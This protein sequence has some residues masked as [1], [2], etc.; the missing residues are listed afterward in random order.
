MGPQKFEVSHVT[1][2]RPFQGQF[3]G[4]ELLQST[5]VQNLKSLCYDMKYDAR[6]RN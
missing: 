4:W 2:P 6:Y 5:V 3:I 1:Y